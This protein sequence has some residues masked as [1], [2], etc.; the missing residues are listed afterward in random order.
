MP[1]SL[2]ESGKGVGTSHMANLQHVEQQ[3]QQ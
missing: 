3:D 2:K 1:A